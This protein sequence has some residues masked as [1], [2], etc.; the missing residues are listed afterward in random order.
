L[1][2]F[3]EKTTGLRYSMVSGCGSSAKVTAV[4][5]NPHTLFAHSQADRPGFMALD[6]LRRGGVRLAVIES[7]PD[8]EAREVYSR[9]L[10]G[11]APS[12][13]LSRQA[14]AHARSPQR[15]GSAPSAPQQPP[16]SGDVPH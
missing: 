9:F 4:G 2:V 6:F 1:Q 5:H 7:F 3:D 10:I 16:G 15:H 8:S 11:A 13:R 12:A 14:P